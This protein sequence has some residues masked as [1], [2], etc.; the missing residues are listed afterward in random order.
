MVLLFLCWNLSAQALI[1]G[2]TTHTAALKTLLGDTVVRWLARHAFHGIGKSN[3][4]DI[5]DY[6]GKKLQGGQNLL[7]VLVEA[8][9]KSLSW[10]EAKAMETV[11]HRI[12]KLKASQQQVGDFLFLDEARANLDSADKKEVRG[13]KEK[14][15]DDAAQYKELLE[16]IRAARSRPNFAKK[17]KADVESRYKGPRVFVPATETLLQRDYKRFRP[18]SSYLWVARNEQAWFTRV[19][20]ARA[21]P[22]YWR[23]EGGEEPALKLAL[24][25]AW[26][27]WP[28]LEGMD[29]GSCP[30]EGLF[31]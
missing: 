20:P 1:W 24:R 27:M 5:M 2:M 9:M 18:P 6:S 7:G 23:R 16:D 3:I 26:K 8:V 19:P 12:A 4:V 15:Q 17:A 14:V 28:E 11:K 29:A 31:P 25:D 10:S 22:R 13:L 30:M 21:Y